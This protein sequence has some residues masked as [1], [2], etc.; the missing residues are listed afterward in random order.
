M[1]NNGRKAALGILLVTVAAVAVFAAAG[2]RRIAQP[3]EPDRTAATAA[4]APAAS[5]A[6]T[7]TYTYTRG[8]SEFPRNWGPFSFASNADA[9][10]LSCLSAGL[11]AFDFNEAG[12]GCRL[13]PCMAAGEPEDVTEQYL[14][15]FGLQPGE[16]GRAWRIPLREDLC[17]QDGT[18]IDASDFVDSARRLLDPAASFPRSDILCADSLSVAGGREYRDQR[19]YIHRENMIADRRTLEDLSP[20]GDGIYRTPEGEPVSLALDYPLEHL[21]YGKTLRF[22]VDAYGEGCFDLSSWPELLARMDGDGLVPLTE[23]SLALFRTLTM[24]NPV[25]GDTEETLSAYFVLSAM[26][27][28]VRWE[29]VGI[30]APGPRELVLV[31]DSPLDGFSLRYAL[32][33]CWLVYAPLY[34]RCASSDGDRGYNGYGTSAETS[35]SCGPYILA[36]YTPDSRYVLLRN[37]TYFGLRDGEGRKYYPATRIEGRYLPEDGERLALFLAGYLDECVP[38]TESIPALG[39]GDA[40]LTVPGDAVYLLLF[41]PDP[42]GLAA[43]EAAAGENVNKTILTRDEFRRALALAI[44]REAFC[45]EVSPRSLPACTLYTPLILGDTG[46]GVP[47]RRT[48]QGQRVAALHADGE[49]DLQTAR[50][51]VNLAY[52]DACQAGLMDEDDVVELCVGIPNAA[53]DYY[54]RGWDFLQ[55]QFT[56]A[57]KGTVLEGR[58]RLTR[59]DDLG[60]DAYAALRENRV[61]LLFGVGWTGN[62]L[63]PVGMMGAYL[64]DDLRCDLSWDLDTAQITVEAREHTAFTAS[65]R[66]WY[67]ILCGETRTVSYGD[68]NSLELSCGDS[69]YPLSR[70]D[71]L[72]ALENAVLLR[73]DV[74]PL[75]QG[76]ARLLRGGQIAWPTEDYVFG[77][78]FGGLKYLTFLCDDAAWAKQ[79]TAGAAG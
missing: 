42:Q 34:E 20:G 32:T 5:E 66:D 43:A 12:D 54:N 35:F 74:Y 39:A 49:Y 65:V 51:A 25:W 67:A 53:S 45:R 44:D 3:P 4:P 2:R 33:D 48:E 10:L 31:L 72:A 8:L 76:C 15:S 61:D 59:L 75:S 77:V 1:K 24:G 41:N 26:A 23:E 29:D 73:G 14:G 58:L 30:L 55:R 9:E 38:G 18:P 17:W 28:A 46:S 68:G 70:P 36:E 79:R 69:G 11:Y 40:C 52:Y 71:I 56:E 64:R 7:P 22:Y 60:A 57:V 50:T 13:V 37:P 6:P 21:L 62:A 16:T 19:S 63:D 27:P 78:G 47:Y